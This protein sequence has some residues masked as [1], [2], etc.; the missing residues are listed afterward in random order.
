MPLVWPSKDVRWALSTTP[1]L[2]EFPGAEM[3]TVVFRTD[4]HVVE[5]VLPRPLRPPPEPL[6]LAFVAS[7][8]DTNFGLAYREGAV[9][10]DASYRGE[11][12]FYTLIMPVDDDAAMVEGRELLGYPKKLA[13]R[14][15][16]ERREAHITGSVVRRG[17]EVIRIDGELGDARALGPTSVLRAGRDLGDAPCLIG[18]SWLFKYFRAASTAG[19]QEAPR[20]IREP[21]LFRP[22]DGLRTASV[23]LKLLSSA[24][25]PLGDVPV[26]DVVDAWYG[27]FD[28]T[29]LPGRTVRRVRNSYRFAPRAFARFD[30]LQLLDRSRVPS[31]S[32]A[33]RMRLRRKLRRY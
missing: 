24:T 31:R 28:N 18:T 14:I 25:D 2:A 21:V 30:S 17:T 32:F 4:P 8:P 23:D 13:D 6:G 29:M 1:F 15:T 26:L 9:C 22:R 27:V 20:L 7:Y 11:T 19:F 10:L 33:E 12:G 3:L 5:R 16:L